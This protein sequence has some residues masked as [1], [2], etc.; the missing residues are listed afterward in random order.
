MPTYMHILNLKLTDFLIYI[1]EFQDI[2]TTEFEL[3]NFCVVVGS[4]ANR[5]STHPEY[6]REMMN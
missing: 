4:T 2:G 6:D 1:M 5:N 3:E